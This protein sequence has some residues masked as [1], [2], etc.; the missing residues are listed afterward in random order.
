MNRID[1]NAAEALK[2]QRHFFSGDSFFKS[3]LNNFLLCVFDLRKCL[4]FFL[5]IL[6]KQYSDIQRSSWFYKLFTQGL[7]ENNKNIFK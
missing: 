6:D 3:D 7:N 2:K 5:H 4:K 1:V